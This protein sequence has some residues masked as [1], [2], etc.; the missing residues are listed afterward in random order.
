MALIN[1][2]SISVWDFLF[3][4]IGFLAA[5]WFFAD[6]DNQH[7]LSTA[8]PSLGSENAVLNSVEIL[9]DHGY[10]VAG[11]ENSVFF[12]PRVRL[13]DSLQHQNGR[14]NTI[15][16]L[17]ERAI[18]NLF[19]YYWRIAFE[20]KIEQDDITIEFGNDEQNGQPVGGNV[21]NLEVRLDTDGKL[22]ALLNHSRILPGEIVNHEALESIMIP[23]IENTGEFWSAFTDSSLSETLEFNLEKS[24]SESDTPDREG[25]LRGQ[26]NRPAEVIGSHQLTREDAFGL[27]EF[28]LAHSG[29]DTGKLRRDTLVTEQ[30]KQIDAVRVRF[31][32]TEPMLG[33]SVVVDLTIAATGALLDLTPTY[34]PGSAGGNEFLALW[35]LAR[36]ALVTLFGIGAIIIFFFRMRARAVDTRSSLVISII[37]GLT[38]PVM[39]LL[40]AAD[41]I[42]LFGGSG[43]WLVTVSTFIQMAMGGALSSVGFFVLTAIGDSIT[44]QHWPDKLNSYDYLRQG[45]LFNKPVGTVLVR[46]VVLAFLLAAFLNTIL[47]LFPHSFIQ[48]EDTDVFISNRVVWPVLY[49]L[50]HYGWFS[51]VIVMG[52]FMVLGSQVFAQTKKRWVAALFM[53]LG[54]AVIGPLILDIGP[55]I[56]EFLISGLMGLGMTLIFL[57][58]DFLTLI[59]SHYL[60]V[61]LVSVSA[62]WMIGKSPDSILFISFVL[63]LVFFVIGGTLCIFL[64][65]E[66]KTL[67]RFIPQYVEELAQEERIKQELQIAREVQQSF[68]PE[69]MPVVQKLDL[70]GDCTPALETGGDYYD[71]IPLDDHRVA[72]AVGD[73][74]GKGIQAAFYMTFIKGILHSL[75]REISSPSDLMKKANKLFYD[76]A[77]KDTFVSLI[78]GILDTEDQTF[79]FAR[80]G[81]NPLIYFNNQTNSWEELKPTGL[82]LG[83][84]PGEKFDD[85]MKELTISLGPDDM[86][87]LYTD[88]IIEA[89]SGDHQFYGTKRLLD[90]LKQNVSLSSSQILSAVSND[91]TGFVGKAQQHDDMTM[92]IIKYSGG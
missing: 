26:M 72:V 48:L 2:R 81:H 38:I 68:L 25:M 73:V 10:E 74:S 90:V 61:T 20:K 64:G 51:L 59:I 87:L 50:I 86:L 91:I 82:G 30:F 27:A 12:R 45:F 39:V 79:R 44:R 52:I 92:L 63:L 70:A 89:L 31:A 3:V 65:K 80:A 85:N 29:W 16:M 33:Q 49:Y 36:V 28:H 1:N 21:S 60:L 24:T 69:K 22:I 55:N 53:V 75:C 46:S 88:G 11:F 8:N 9:S 41:S 56:Q 19:P 13:L 15:R 34:N 62:G 35:A 66:E 6:F 84:T 71:V 78:Y 83:I 42:N 18:A 43:D 67:P 17:N 32:N 5:I 7:P 23:P 4:A 14:R 47:W 54:T 58:W 40:S 77:Q 57:K 37:F 76:N